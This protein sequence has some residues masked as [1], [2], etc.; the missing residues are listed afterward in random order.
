MSRITHVDV[1]ARGVH[2]ARAVL[3]P[4]GVPRLE[5]VHGTDDD[6]RRI[7]LEAFGAENAVALHPDAFFQQMLTAFPSGL[8]SAFGAY[9]AVPRHAS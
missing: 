1:Y 5:A 9:A 4:G 3:S 7:C 2:V 6:L 8:A